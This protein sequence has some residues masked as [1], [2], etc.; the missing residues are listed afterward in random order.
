MRLRCNNPKFETLHSTTSA[1]FRLQC[2]WIDIL[3][4]CL[5]I[6]RNKNRP[7]LCV[8]TIF[9][10]KHFL[11]SSFEMFNEADVT[12]S[13]WRIQF[14]NRIQFSFPS[15]LIWSSQIIALSSLVHLNRDAHFIIYF[16]QIGIHFKDW[17]LTVWPDW[18]IFGISW[19]QVLLQK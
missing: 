16:T 5:W 19:Q 11:S 10:K 8:R 3:P 13:R 4:I 15:T 6:V 1:L 12:S 14:R 7:W 2:D 9:E 17:S 18:A